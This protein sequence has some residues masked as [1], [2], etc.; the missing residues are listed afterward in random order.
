MISPFLEARAWRI[1]TQIVRR[2]PANLTLLESTFDDGFYILHS[3]VPRDAAGPLEAYQHRLIDV[4]RHGTILNR[5]GR[6][7]PQALEEAG[8]EPTLLFDRAQDF[9]GKLTAELELPDPRPLPPSTP[10]TLAF[11]FA[12]AWLQL[13]TALGRSGPWT[14]ASVPT[15]PSGRP[16]ARTIP[17]P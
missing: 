14:C 9:Y 7:L 2:A 13:A 1:A 10:E 12:S 4:N 17:P 3:I 11:R 6:G 15:P 16:W 8:R 5:P